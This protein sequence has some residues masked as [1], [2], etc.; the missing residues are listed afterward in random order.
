VHNPAAAAETIQRMAELNALG[1]AGQGG[2]T[3]THNWN[4]NSND[5]ES[6]QRMIQ[7][8]AKARAIVQTA[9]NHLRRSGYR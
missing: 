8:P 3:H 4:V 9:V 7:N 5:A 1:G 6:I 2:E